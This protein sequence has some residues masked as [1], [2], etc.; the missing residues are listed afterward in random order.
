MVCRIYPSE[1]DLRRAYRQFPIDPK[2]YDLLGFRYQAKFYFDTRCPF[3]LRSSAMIC[4]RTTKAAVHI[5]TEQGFLAD[6]YLDDFY[7]AEYPSL[8]VSA[9]SQLGQLFHQLGLDSDPDKYSP[10]STSM[11]CLGILDGTVALTLE[12]PTTRL[13]DLQA[14]LRT[15]QAAPFFTKEQLQS[16]LG[17]LSFVTACVKPGR[18][19][20]IRLLNSL[21]EYKRPAGHL[22]LFPLLCSWTFSGGL[23][24]FH[25]FIV[26]LLLSIPSGILRV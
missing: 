10:P 8:A 11:I 19:F 4:Q 7:G 18:I 25:S 24:F 9:F 16:L 2:D 14:E 21:R 26:F 15:R 22:I 6:V 20:M 1:E 12:F 3:R 13:T 5:F 17:K 23:I